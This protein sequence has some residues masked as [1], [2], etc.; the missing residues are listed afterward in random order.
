MVDFCFFG[1]LEAFFFPT[2]ISSCGFGFIRTS[3]PINRFVSLKSSG[4][5]VMDDHVEYDYNPGNLPQDI[6]VAI[7]LVATCASQTEGIVEM[8]IGGCLGI[9]VEYTAAVTSHMNAPMRD[10]T[11]RAAAEI[12]LDDLDALDEL[13]R[14]MDSVNASFVKRNLYLHNM[15]GTDP[16]G[17][18]FATSVTARGSVDVDIVP[19]TAIGIREDA[20][21]IYMAGMELM[22]FIRKYKILP[23]FPSAHRPRDHK[24]KAA[25]KKRRKTMLKGG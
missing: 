18:I 1:F 8:A 9:T 14:I 6:L 13:D 4:F 20:M 15:I 5:L 19:L 17:N 10:Q 7:G 25:R 2:F 3:A 24:T 23:K 12:K 11:L 16:K 22:N 21:A